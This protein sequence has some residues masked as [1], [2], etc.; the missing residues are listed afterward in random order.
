MKIV[1]TKLE[2][3]VVI[4]HRVFADDRGYFLES[5]NKRE[6]A[7]QGLDLEFVQDN[8]SRSKKHTL[9]GLHYQKNPK[10]QGKLVMVNFG[11]IFDVAVDITKGSPTFGQWVG[12]EL[13]CQNRKALYVPPGFAHG[14]VVTSDTADVT[15]KCTEYYSPEHDRGIIWSDPDIGIKWPVEPRFF[16]EKDLKAP[17]LQNA[18]INF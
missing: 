9:R 6:F 17:L 11:T 7:K 5:H 3:V 4:E 1:K 15:Y 16:S 2:G 18:D 8:S 12:V 14:F 13:S 10:A